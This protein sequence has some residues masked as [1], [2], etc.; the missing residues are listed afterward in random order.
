MENV[1][2]ENSKT[3]GLHLINS[4]SLIKN[5]I[6][7]DSKIGVL[8]EGSSDTSTINGCFFNNNTEYGLRIIGGASPK[9][10][11][12]QFTYNGT[13]GDQGAII[14]FSAYPEFKNNQATNNNINGI[15]IHWQS[16]FEKDTTWAA[17]LPYVPIANF[18]E[19]PTVVDGTT[20]TLKPGV[21]IKPFTG[22]FLTALV[23][24][25]TLKAEATSGSEIVFTSIKD[26]S[27]GGDTN[28]DS[29]TTTPTIHDWKNIKFDAT[30]TGSVFDHVFMY[31]GTGAPPMDINASA[32]VDIKDTVDYTP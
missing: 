11:N 10:F 7:R 6:F 23:V 1:I 12:N 25:G 4:N 20:L 21:I 14:F 17:A 31:Y 15:L 18:G 30:S 5:S 32:S 16:R 26:D 28:N 8:I 19:Y 9:I 22:P 24:K 29:N 27:F 13:V 2:M 3:R